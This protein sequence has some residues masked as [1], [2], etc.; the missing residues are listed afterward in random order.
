ML[1]YFR[2]LW[3]SSTH[4]LKS[5]NIIAIIFLC[6]LINFLLV[7]QKKKKNFNESFQIKFCVFCK[8]M[9]VFLYMMNAHSTHLCWIACKV[10]FLNH[11][12]GSRNK[13]PLSK[14]F[15]IKKSF[16]TYVISARNFIR[17]IKIISMTINLKR[18]LYRTFIKNET[19]I[20]I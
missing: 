10:Y 5:G 13:K 1:Q 15:Y 12:K 20:K 9:Y 17:I 19:F 11:I 6:Q 2:S 8:L 7:N 4:Q 16:T 18:F 3:K 14:L